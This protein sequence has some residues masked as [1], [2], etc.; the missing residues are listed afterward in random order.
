MLFR[1]MPE[2]KEFG[3]LGWE[4]CDEDEYGDEPEM[5]RGELENEELL[6]AMEKVERGEDEAEELGEL[7]FMATSMCK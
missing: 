7:I 2:P 3:Q 4:H 6:E 1:Y 5:S